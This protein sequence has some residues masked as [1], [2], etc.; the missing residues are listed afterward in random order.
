AENR[1]VTANWIAAAAEQLPESIWIIA[2]G[3][4]G[5]GP[6]VEADFVP[7]KIIPPS[8]ESL[9]PTLYT[10]WAEL[11]GKE[12]SSIPDELL[13]PLQWAAL[14]G[15]SPAEL[16]LRVMLALQTG[17]APDR[18][19]DVLQTWLQGLVPTPKLGK[20]DQET[21]QD[22]QNY[23]LNT[24]CYIAR[25]QDLDKKLLS[26]D[27]LSQFIL[28]QF[29]PED[30]RASKL[31]NIVRKAIQK[32]KI[33]DKT[34]EE[35]KI[36]HY[37]WSNYLTA[38]ALTQETEASSLLE[39]HLYEGSWQF[40]LECFVGLSDATP[41][42][43]ALL[44]NI[45]TTQPP[46]TIKADESAL[47]S[48]LRLARWAILAPA[49]AEWRKHVMKA[50]AQGFTIVEISNPQRQKLGRALALIAGE[51]A[52]AFFIK[53]LRHPDTNVRAVA[54][55][56]LGWV[57]TP[58]EIDVLTAALRDR[59]VA[60]R[61]NAVLALADQGT[62]GALRILMQ[63]LEYGDEQ[64]VLTIGEVF[65]ATPAGWDIL[66]ES[67][68]SPDILVR[69]AV[70]HGLGFIR[71]PWAT[72]ILN[73]MV[74]EDPEWLVRS[75]AEAA[76]KEQETHREMTAVV[77]SPPQVEQLEWLMQW[78][79]K[80]G[81]GLGVGDAAIEALNRAIRSPEP[82]TRILAAHTLAHIGR[83]DHLTPLR[84]MLMDEYPAVR[85]AAQEAID[86]IE[87]RYE[88]DNE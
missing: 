27:E 26:K 16:T 7:L 9:L 58:R 11:L 15:A 73:H 28:T 30:E 66:K 33:M 41:L 24:L 36:N 54:L 2:S 46:R 74:I 44:K 6:L 68:S 81:L 43:Y 25:S 56:G 67:A 53:A 40:I 50:L 69:R 72:E 60:I 83:W 18:A 34:G 5:Y 12:D 55:R 82:E 17:K 38:I 4:S 22:I 23:I 14:S 64:L 57:G 31:E 65:A 39:I 63:T 52:R 1:K 3:P 51:G 37:V 20:E 86:L 87:Q 78:A 71:Q 10:G 32:S 21:E 8:G 76:L 88:L 59:D 45:Y 75:S 35:W 62:P 19:N 42:V 79:S 61:R 70:A 13:P 47:K 29:P 85:T 80:Q 49:E 48:L 77:N 84:A